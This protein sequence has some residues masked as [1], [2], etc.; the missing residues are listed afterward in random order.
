MLKS[1]NFALY[2]KK[3][4]IK[5]ILFLYMFVYLHVGIAQLSE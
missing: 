1:K 3:T 5:V 4:Y 2:A